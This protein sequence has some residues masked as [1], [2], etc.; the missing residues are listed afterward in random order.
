MQVDDDANTASSKPTSAPA[1]G[2]SAPP[3]KVL[4]FPRFIIESPKPE[5]FQAKV[6]SMFLSLTTPISKYLSS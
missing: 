6:G 1:S 5:A 2:S 3:C 4:K